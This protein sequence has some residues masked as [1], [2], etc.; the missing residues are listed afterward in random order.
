MIRVAHGRLCRSFAPRLEPLEDRLTPAT[1]DILLAGADAGATPALRVFDAESHLLTHKFLAYR[2]NFQGGV[3]VAA[4]D[5]TGDGIPDI[6]T[7]PGPGLAP[8]VKVFD[9]QTHAL[10]HPFLAFNAA[11]V[12]GVN[13]AAG[14]VNKDGIDDIIVSAG[15]RVKVLDGTKLD[16]TRGSGTIAV[17]ATLANFLP[18]GAAAGPVN[19][20]AGDVNGDQS[21]D[22][23]VGAGPGAGPH[24]KVFSGANPRRVL[25]RFFAFAPTLTG[26]VSVAAADLDGDG[27]DDIIA[28]TGAGTR[29]HVKV[30]SGANSARLL[31]E[32][33]PF[34]DFQDGVRV[35]AADVDGDDRPDIIVGQAAVA[36]PHVKV[37]SG[38][39]RATLQSFFPFGPAFTG[40]FV[41]GGATRVLPTRHLNDL[42][43][44]RSPTNA[45]NTVLILTLDPFDPAAPAGAF[46]RLAYRFNIDVNGD[47]V[48]DVVYE[49]TFR[50]AQ[51]AAAQSV[52]LTR[53]SDGAATTLAL[54]DT[55]S[56]LAIAGGG[57]FR[58]GL[59]DNP[60][61]FDQ[62]GYDAF[63][64]GAPFPRPLGTAANSFGP[65][66]NTLALVLEVPSSG[67]A[68]AN[69]LIAVWGSASSD[70]RQVDRVGRPLFLETLVPPVPR[71]SNFPFDPE[72]AA[73]NTRAFITGSPDADVDR[74]LA[75]AVAIFEDFYE[76]T[77]ADANALASILLPDMMLF[78]IGNPNGFGTFVTSG[79]GQ[80]GFFGGTRLGN[81][82]RLRDDVVDVLFNVYTNGVIATD[83][84]PDDNGTRVTDG[85]QGTTPAFPYLGAANP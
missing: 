32:L 58:A 46:P 3:R 67:L 20:A 19:L 62:A 48:A 55:G 22:I 72:A 82:R 83:N 25:H 42:Y 29:A 61:F 28:G 73:A 44:F 80:T 43:V 8:R 84:V 24:V 63:V 38:R 18:L 33:F 81:G 21:A 6:I 13:V 37:F 59:Q 35:A 5:V 12:G 68:P 77:D 69:A 57:T 76:R 23:I 26:G 34:G 70:H 27:T 75:A 36:G 17:R 50:P 52:T 79:T 64:N 11:T 51:A 9:G 7:A 16:Q 56:N 39:T 71:G 85:N 14:D 45:N 49:A 78:Q 1:P 53:T 31:R 15:S 10:L 60:F 41:A 2:A 54:G 30:F 65:N 66:V 47:A 74:H 40:V 4:G